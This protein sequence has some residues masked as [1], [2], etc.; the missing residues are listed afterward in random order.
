MRAGL[1]KIISAFLILFSGLALAES[2]K[3]GWDVVLSQKQFEMGD[4]AFNL[5]SIRP[6]NIARLIEKTPP[7]QREKL[8]WKLYRERAAINQMLH[9][10]SRFIFAESV[11]R[12]MVTGSAQEKLREHLKK[13]TTGRFPFSAVT[14]YYDPW[15]VHHLF[16]MGIDFGEGLPVEMRLGGRGLDRLPR[17]KADIGPVPICYVDPFGK[18]ECNKEVS[19]FLS[20]IPRRHGDIAELRSL[21]KSKASPYDFTELLYYVAISE[22]WA[23]WGGTELEDTDRPPPLTGTMAEKARELSSRYPHIPEE[24]IFPEKQEYLFVDDF[25]AHTLSHSRERLYFQKLGLKLFLP[26][27]RDRD[28]PTSEARILHIDSQNLKDKT[29]ELLTKLPVHTILQAGVIAENS[30]EPMGCSVM[31]GVRGINARNLKFIKNPGAMRAASARE[32]AVPIDSYIR[33]IA[34]EVFPELRKIKRY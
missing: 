20:S 12:G 18:P 24:L 10:F 27:F 13:I 16:G 7:A 4:E 9:I 6:I 33:Q 15:E 3:P 30:M 8:I 1:G 29:P 19:D 17:K 31:I 21:T 5:I 14:T 26:P 34:E 25:Y 22:G 11:S 28:F 32:F 2:L 23:Y